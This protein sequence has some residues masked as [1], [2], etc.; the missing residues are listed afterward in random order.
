LAHYHETLP[1]LAGAH[2][3]AGSIYSLLPYDPAKHPFQDID[4]SLA[5]PRPLPPA[6]E[7]QTIDQRASL[8]RILVSNF[9]A[10]PDEMATIGRP[11]LDANREASQA[12][13]NTFFVGNHPE[14]DS[15]AFTIAISAL[16][17]ESLGYG[18]DRP[19]RRII[20]V[21]EAVKRYGLGDEAVVDI[22]TDI[23]QVAFTAPGTER[24]RKLDKA[25]R[26]YINRRTLAALNAQFDA[27]E[28]VELTMAYEGQTGK[29]LH[30]PG[31]GILQLQYTSS[32][33]SNQMMARPDVLTTPFA[34][35]K[36]P[37][38]KHLTIAYGQPRDITSVEEAKSLGDEI[39]YLS[40]VASGNL[41]WAA[42]SVPLY[43]Q[44][45][46]EKSPARLLGYLRQAVENIRRFRDHPTYQHYV[47]GQTTATREQ[48][49]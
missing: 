45:I 33:G 31:D 7:R 40:F 13:L 42:E 49:E 26:D 19:E 46:G 8:G 27:E 10:L 24:G 15:I 47:I 18:L 16:A 14:F 9:T 39:A 1:L 37:T 36:D 22:L 43:R 5:A 21:S 11:V 28:S 17:N 29:S 3:G 2:T 41:V 32:D 38:T 4:C 6:G 20:P 25:V 12:G 34:T 44:A 30:I 48:S 35:Y 23:A